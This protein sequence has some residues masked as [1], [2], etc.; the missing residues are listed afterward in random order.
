MAL[1]NSFLVYLLTTLA[2]WR[3]NFVSKV[4]EMKPQYNAWFLVLLAV[5]MTLAFTINAALEIWCVSYRGLKFTSEWNWDI[6][7]VSVNAECK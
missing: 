2:S 1:A 4:Q 3:Y 6:W 5:L 7:G